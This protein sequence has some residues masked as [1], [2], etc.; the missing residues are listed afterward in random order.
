MIF[1]DSGKKVLGLIMPMRWDRL[2]KG[3]P[4]SYIKKYAMDNT[5]F[6]KS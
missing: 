6:S 2:P 4:D 5:A 1:G 3:V